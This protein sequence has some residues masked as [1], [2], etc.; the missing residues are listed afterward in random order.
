MIGNIRGDELTNEDANLVYRYNNVEEVKGD[1]ENIITHH[2]EYQRPRLKILEDYYRGHNTGILNRKRRVNMNRS[3]IRITNPF[4]KNISRF[5][6]GYITGNPVKVLTNDEEMKRLI[7][8]VDKRNDVASLNSEIVL[9]LSKFGRAYELQF[10]KKDEGD[11]SVL[12]D[13]NNTIVIYDNTV[14]SDVLCAIHYRVSDRVGNL[15]EGEEERRVIVSLYTDKEVIQLKEGNLEGFIYE[16]EEGG[17]VPHKYEEVPITEYQ[18]DRTR[19]GDYEGIIGLIDAYDST[20]SDIANF[21]SDFNESMLAITGNLQN[22]D[23]EGLEEDVKEGV[24]LALDGGTDNEGRTE[25]IT[26]E[27]LVREY[28]FLG[29]DTYLNRLREDIHKHSYIPDMSELKFGGNIS[30]TAMRYKLIDLE[31]LVDMKSRAMER[32]LDKRY[33]LVARN[34]Q[35]TKEIPEIVDTSLTYK[36]GANMPEAIEEEMQSVY[37]M[38]GEFSLDTLLSTVSFIENTEVEKKKILAEK[39]GLSYE[40]VEG[41]EPEVYRRAISMIRVKDFIDVGDLKKKIEDEK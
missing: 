24:M 37:S 5:V 21:F 39:T 27:Y 15:K 31:Q 7:D 6:Q 40:E 2:I 30:G 10:Y 36:W 33:R 26:A 35:F 16:E 8:E 3:D 22:V 23:W 32:G 18:V 20:E 9:D 13:V 41:L 12:L 4:A 19:Q 25:P 38:G 29:S 17:V 1:L 11:R 14:T 28:D 34:K